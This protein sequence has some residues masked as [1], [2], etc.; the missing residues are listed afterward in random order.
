VEEATRD[1]ATDQRAPAPPQGDSYPPRVSTAA[2]ISTVLTIPIL[3]LEGMRA[4][5][6]GEA[7]VGSMLVVALL[8]LL[9]GIVIALGW[10][11]V[12]RFRGEEAGEGPLALSGRAALLILAGGAWLGILANRL[13]CFLELSSC[14]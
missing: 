3:L 9:L 4:V 6:A 13:P 7:N 14:S 1:A 2:V 5:Q 11:I 8:W 12:R 10:S